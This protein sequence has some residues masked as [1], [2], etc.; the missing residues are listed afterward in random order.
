VTTIHAERHGGPLANECLKPIIKN[1]AVTDAAIMLAIM[2]DEAPV[3][4]TPFYCK[5]AGTVTSM[6]RE[7]R[8]IY[9][10]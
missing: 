2:A 10:G 8:I 4:R 1:A 9:S 7:C 3:G 6:R 5:C